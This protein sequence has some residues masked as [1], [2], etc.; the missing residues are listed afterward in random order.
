[1]RASRKAGLDP[2]KINCV[3]LRGFNEDQIVNFGK[4]AREERVVRFIDSCHFEEDRVW[5]PKL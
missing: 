3:L 1:M 4:F 5:T 2:V